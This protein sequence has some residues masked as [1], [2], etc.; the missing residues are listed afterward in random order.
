[1]VGL[2]RETELHVATLKRRSAV[3]PP[4]SKATPCKPLL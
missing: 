1:V 3:R 4:N 2:E